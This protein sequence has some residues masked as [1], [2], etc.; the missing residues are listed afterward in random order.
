MP[1]SYNAVWC[2]ATRVPTSICFLLNAVKACLPVAPSSPHDPA[3]V[4]NGKARQL[5]YA[6]LL[7]ES[8]GWFGAFC[9]HLRACFAHLEVCG[10]LLTCFMICSFAVSPSALGNL[11]HPLSTLLGHQVGFLVFLCL[12]VLQYHSTAMLLCC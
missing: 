10:V 9:A 2:I 8:L 3:G 5:A 11:A 6:S 12:L 1:V 4:D 7:L